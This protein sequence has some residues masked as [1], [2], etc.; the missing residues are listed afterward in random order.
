MVKRLKK[1]V[2]AGASNLMILKLIDA[3]NRDENKFEPIGLIDDDKMQQ[4]KKHYGIP[5]IGEINEE[6]ISKFSKDV[7][8][9]ANIVGG[10]IETRID[11]IKKL[12]SFGVKYATLVHPSIDMNYVKIGKNCILYQGIHLSFQVEIKDHCIITQGVKV[13][14]NCMIDDYCFIAPGAI[15]DSRINLSTGT[16]VGSGAIV[17]KGLNVGQMSFIGAGSVVVRNVPDHV[18]VF[19]NPAQVIMKGIRNRSTV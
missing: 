18:T 2:I 13:G 19:G 3:I 1:L 4:G 16:I 10:N 8:Y 14:H 17:L 6:T 7:F 11:L 15:L 12:D 9:I 5:V